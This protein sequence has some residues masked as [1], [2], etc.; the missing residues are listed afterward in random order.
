MQRQPVAFLPVWISSHTPDGLVNHSCCLW[1][2]WIS[3]VF[4]CIR[5]Q[6]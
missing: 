1:A 5:N 2:T 4:I 6:A 3:N